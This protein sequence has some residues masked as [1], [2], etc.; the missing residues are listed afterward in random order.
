MSLSAASRGA[1]RVFSVFFPEDCRICNAAL[2]EISRVPV[3]TRC[4]ESVSPL[5]TGHFCARCQT[6]FLNDRPLD[7]QGLCAL[8]AIGVNRFDS[9]HSYGSY[10][11][12]LREL[13]HLFKYEAVTPL[14][15]RFGALLSRVA[16][17][18]RAFDAVVPMPL[19]WWRHWRRGFNQAELL[20]REL[21]RRMGIP[22]AR[23]VKRRKLTATQTG[24]TSA[25]R[26]RNVV[27]AFRVFAH[28]DVAG[29]R[30]LLV[31]DVLTT[32]ATVNACAAALKAAGAS[33]VAVLTLARADRRSR[34]ELYRPESDSASESEE[35]IVLPI[36]GASL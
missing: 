23:V 27:G 5:E 31:D 14:A 24:L 29:K 8:C 1:G 11:G 28:R 12:A 22:L 10:D 20:G 34:V 26:R 33:Y 19:H 21:A 17:R 7:E 32:G 3:C 4:L 16:P 9:C 25:A 36:S 35:R 6:P 18:D 15:G 13:I 30:L 2:V